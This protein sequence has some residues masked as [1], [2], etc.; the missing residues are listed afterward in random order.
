MA[1]QD[2][3]AF[4]ELVR[5]HVD[6][7]YSA[8]RRQLTEDPDAAR[9]VTQA[10]FCDLARKARQIPPNTPIAGWLY[11]HTSFI[12]SN[13][14]RSN[15][16]RDERERQAAAL[17]EVQR[18][19]ELNWND[20][21]PVIDDAMGRLPEDDRDA[22]V[23]RFF[24]NR[25]LREIGAMLGL[26]EDAARKRVDRAL[27]KLRTTLETRGIAS[28]L[29]ALSTMVSGNAVMPAPAG[30]AATVSHNAAA[31]LAAG[32][33]G[34]AGI[35]LG[36][37]WLW[38]LTAAA[39]IAAVGG[40]LVAYKNH[41]A[42]Q[43]TRA[44]LE[45]EIAGLRQQLADAQ[46]A[47]PTADS[48]GVDKLR[49]ELAT[50]RGEVARQRR[51]QVKA[52]PQ[53]PATASQTAATEEAKPTVHILV[54]SRWVLMADDALE[55]LELAQVLPMNAVNRLG[56][57]QA[58]ELLRRMEGHEGVTLLSAP[59]VTTLSKRQA[60]VSVVRETVVGNQRFASG[61]LLDVIPELGDN[62]EVQLS[63]I[64][65]WKINERVPAEGIVEL[66]AL[67]TAQ[68]TYFN[69]ALKPGERI[70]FRQP[71]PEGARTWIEHSIPASDDATA[72][73]LV[74]IVGIDLLD[75]A[76]G[77]ITQK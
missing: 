30:V 8:A 54:D 26:T 11:R 18:S 19:A 62:H 3:T 75:P 63:L 22:L 73:S 55:E 27:D 49:T 57:E 4:A 23:L 14:S 59:K 65:T 70:A 74:V 36:T 25:K 60:Q 58:E 10:V 20:L 34:S 2:E 46:P 44:Q 76:G 41:R 29:A 51:Q 69:V 68:L 43:A 39:S 35:A 47:T 17:Q 5:R 38:G 40:W 16:R 7:V 77:R 61:P 37:R 21:A 50:L 6:L 15:R 13:H 71:V 1:T 64:P 66:P 32:A 42:L 33:I 45:Q 72:H 9:D 53:S 52:Q 31:V 56:Q 12:A 67:R 48:A 24:E 28:T